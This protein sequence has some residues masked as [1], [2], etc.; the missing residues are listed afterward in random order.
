MEGFE[1]APEEGRLVLA[2]MA[3]F[4]DSP[5][6][7]ITRRYG[8]GISFTELISADGIV[9]KNQKTLGML[10][11]T[12]QE[13]PVVVQLFG[14]EVETLAEAARIVSGMG[15]D[16]IDLNMGCSVRK[17]AG[18]GAGAGLLQTPHIAAEM[19]SRMRQTSGLPVSAKIRI[20]WNAKELNH[21]SVSSKLQ[22]A[23]ASWVSVHGRTAAQGYSGYADWNAIAEVKNNLHIPVFGNGDIK[24]Y[25]RALARMSQSGVDRVLIGRAAIGNP[26]IFSPDSQK[27]KSIE[28]RKEMILEHL[29][30][31][32]EYYEKPY[33]LTLFRKHVVGYI[34][35]IPEAASIRN[36]L[37]TCE[38]PGVFLQIVRNL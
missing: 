28:R 26:D 30:L 5:F 6:R 1:S 7:R 12:E 23:G 2:P 32:L 16:G 34:R 22:E 37:V 15:F 25:S 8:S 38:D 14:S 35:G 24:S 11:Y 21:L 3:G 17:V 31:M 29:E 9:R 20:G 18:R 10:H 33:G 27:E 4:S 13:R 19:I 36:R